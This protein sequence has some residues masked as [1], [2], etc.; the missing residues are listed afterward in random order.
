[1]NT[2][3]IGLVA[4]LPLLMVVIAAYITQDAFAEKA[5]GSPSTQSPK[6]YDSATD[7]VVCGDDLCEA[8]GNQYEN[9]GKAI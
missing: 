9:I 5:D 7:N 2:K 4:I 1:M 3:T 8:N 6:S